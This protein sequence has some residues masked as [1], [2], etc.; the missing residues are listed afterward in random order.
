MTGFDWTPERD[1][2]LIACRRERLSYFTCARIIGDGCTAPD[3]EARMKALGDGRVPRVKRE[4]SA[5]PGEPIRYKT[6]PYASAQEKIDNDRAYY[7]SQGL[8]L[9]E[10]FYHRAALACFGM[11]AAA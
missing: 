8:R 2:R 7:A 3:A 1:D 10:W 11:G 4:E 5:T 9:P 6:G